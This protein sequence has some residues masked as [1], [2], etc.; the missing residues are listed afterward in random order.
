M[1]KVFPIVVELLVAAWRAPRY[2]LIRMPV[3]AA[4][5]TSP[6]R[7]HLLLLVVAAVVPVLVY[8][9]IMVVAFGRGERASTER[10]LRGTTRAL[11]LAVDREIETSIKALEALA[12]SLHL[13]TD[14]YNM[15]ERHAGRVLATQPGWRAVILID[16]R[17]EVI[18]RTSRVGAIGARTSLAGRPYF[19]E[20]KE[21]LRPA[22]SDVLLD[23][24]TGAPTIAIVVPVV[25]GGRLR[26]GVAVDLE[27]AALSRFL[28][29]QNLPPDWTGTIMD[30]E[31]FV[32][33]RSRVP[34]TWLGRPAGALLGGLEGNAGWI[35]GVDV[36]GVPAYAAYS[37]SAFT[38]W[39]VAIAV[40]A[41]TVDAPLRS[42]L[43]LA[44]AGGL[45]V[46]LGGA[47]LAL[48]VGRRIA[49]P[50]LR[51]VK[52]AEALGQGRAAAPTAS[53]VT[54][55]N[56]LAAALEA[57]A[58][59]R[60]RF[61][62]ALRDSEAQ[63]RA[64]FSS[65][66]DAI[67]VLDT[68]G[69]TIDANPAAED[70]FGVPR[71]RLVGRSL[72]EAAAVG[73]TGAVWRD[74]LA[75]GAVVGV[76]RLLRPDGTQRD[77][78]F[79]ATADVLPGRHV[80]V[81]RDVTARRQMEEDLRRSEREATAVADLSRRMNERLDLDAILG[82]VCETARD[83][84][85]A[86]SA[87]IALPDAEAPDVMV[88]RHRAPVDDPP[89]DVARIERGHGFGGLV[90]ATGRPQ[91]SA[92]HL[93]LAV[94]AV[95]ILDEGVA[96][97]LYV[98]NRARWPF[99]DADEALL[100]RLAE[101][102]T[103]AIR[104]ARLLAREQTARAD[105]EAANRSKD[106]FLA[107]LSHELRTPL[108]AMLGWVRM[109]R[110]ARLNPEQAARALETI[111]RNTLWQA[112]LIDDLLDVSRIISGKMQLE[113]QPVEVGA[114]VGAA[115]EAL[116]RDA[117]AKGVALDIVLE[118]GAAVVNG[119]PVRLAQ[120]VA[121]LVSNAIKFTPAGG[122]VT[123]ELSRSDNQVVIRV[124]DTGAGI[125]AG[126]LPHVFD[127][128]RQGQHGRGAGGL[129]LGL[130]IVRH[131]VTLHGGTVTAHSEGTGRGAVFAVT[132]PLSAAPRG[133]IVGSATRAARVARPLEG[134]RVLA[135]DDH[136]D[137]RE[138]VR[139]ALV[140]R[141]AEVYTAASVSE[142]LGALETV[143]VDVL[144]S[145]LGMPGADG[146]ALVA[147]L[148]ERERAGGRAPMV[149]IALTAYASLH[150]RSQ[151]LAAGFD[152]HVAKPVDPDALTDAVAGALER[153]QRMGRRAG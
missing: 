115:M 144:V 49:R 7:R 66:L 108:T 86:D 80:A 83:A 75:K 106:D 56:H 88:L 65:T 107:T 105:F 4:A 92:D 24:A 34:E 18:M 132:L 84:C 138:L 74:L 69:T 121:N 104:N 50:I 46:L 16:A 21:L 67:I 26:H 122:R 11:T 119:D 150:D 52:V 14:D 3:E 48:I 141:G 58:R 146:F 85:G 116:R 137:A 12:A 77:V 125:E 17:G 153:A 32:V 127:R 42:S 37:R 76:F 142:A 6:L 19:K 112:K 145:D 47:L 68:D 97:L 103:S 90:M 109:L 87:A 41:K 139:V 91:R 31:G 78:E 110:G 117:E 120:V 82:L 135:V 57:A 55:V 59:E 129:G 151:A 113:R 102:A 149:A 9:T 111:E 100:V 45:L 99:G 123:V 39:T 2:P 33:A 35:R 94:L 134:V 95:P 10:G 62:R 23:R 124:R 60:D 126:L 98:A 118:P 93:G 114:V 140:D 152:L 15:F 128:F 71:D 20:M 28:S 40:P 13:D 1:G 101:Q 5:S 72:H 89:P 147:Q 43:L 38:G 29:S 25:R 96:G 53:A 51:L 27:P 81:V 63:L 133:P 136:P 130:A 22:L 36:D 148:R 79:S 30:R 54:E 61:E 44:T 64:I 70:L 8:A 131:I 73:E 143:T